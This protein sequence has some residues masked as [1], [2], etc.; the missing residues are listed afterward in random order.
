VTELTWSATIGKRVRTGDW[1]DQAVP[2]LVKAREAIDEAGDEF[3]LKAGRREVAAQLVDYFMEEAK[4]VYVIYEVWTQ[5]FLDWLSGKGVDADELATE[6]ERLKRLMAYPDG[7][8]L[9]PSARWEALR[10]EQKKRFRAMNYPSHGTS[11]HT[12]YSSIT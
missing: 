8:P 6:L 5:G 3:G 1:A 12:A 7:S 11:N 4:V 10:M 2:T 9:D